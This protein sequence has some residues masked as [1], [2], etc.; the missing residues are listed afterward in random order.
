MNNEKLDERLR[1]V[2]ATSLDRALEF[3]IDSRSVEQL[4]AVAQLAAQCINWE[5]EEKPPIIGFQPKKAVAPAE[6]DTDE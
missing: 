6:G 2:L 5:E 1:D 4:G 3:A